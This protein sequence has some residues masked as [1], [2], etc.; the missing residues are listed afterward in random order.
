MAAPQQLASCQ[1]GTCTHA[2]PFSSLLMQCNRHTIMCR[3]VTIH[4]SERIKLLASRSCNAAN[5]WCGFFPPDSY[6]DS[7]SDRLVST[8]S[9]VVEWHVAPPRLRNI[10]NI[11]C[12]PDLLINDALAVLQK[13]KL[14]ENFSF[15]EMQGSCIVTG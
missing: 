9:Q 13:K 4:Y 7:Q 3:T 1:I 12:N 2:G 8:N 6:S 5:R 14:K 15:V 10:K 11:D